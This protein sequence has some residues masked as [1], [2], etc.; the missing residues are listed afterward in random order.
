M[1]NPQ[2]KTC[3]SQIDV[4]FDLDFD[5]GLTPHN[6]AQEQLAVFTFD[7]DVHPSI[8]HPPNKTSPFGVDFG[9]S[10]IREAALQSNYFSAPQ[11]AKHKPKIT[12]RK[13]QNAK[14][15]S[16]SI[17]NSISIATSIATRPPG[18][19]IKATIVRVQ[20]LFIF[21]FRSQSTG[22]SNTKRKTHNKHN[23][24]SVW[25]SARPI[26]E[27]T[28]QIKHFPAPQITNHKA[29][30]HKAANHKAANHKSQSSNHGSR[31]ANHK[32]MLVSIS[33]RTDPRGRHKNNHF[34]ISV[35]IP[36]S[37]HLAR[38]PTKQLTNTNRL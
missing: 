29:A 22:T 34:A 38:P 15:K 7:F 35:S 8:T 36:I 2:I 14:H 26:R 13:L 28:E 6:T 10:P 4:E 21:R 9:T 27:A 20:F 1:R 18:Q 12:K 11:T 32:Y 25:I 31:N 5:C 30:N 33:S 17:G 37:A 3:K 16:I 24:P 23:R 19:H